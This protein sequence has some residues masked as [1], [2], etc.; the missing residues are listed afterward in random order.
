M[1]QYRSGDDNTVSRALSVLKTRAS[2]HDPRVRDLEVTPTGI[3]LDGRHP[4]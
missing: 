3:T 1:L 4:G 2:S